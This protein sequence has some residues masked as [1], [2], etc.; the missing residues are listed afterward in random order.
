MLMEKDW[1][2]ENSKTGQLKGI[3]LKREMMLLDDNLCF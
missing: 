1:D 2:F 3:E